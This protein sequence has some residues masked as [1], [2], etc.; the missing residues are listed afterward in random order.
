MNAINKFFGTILS[1]FDSFTGH[2]VL[3]LFL[4][5]LLVKVLLL[6]FGIKQ[7][8]NSVKQARFKPKEMAI[9]NKYKGRT[10]Q[11]TMQ[12]MQN[13]IMELYQKEGYNPMGGCLPLLIQMPIILIL[14][15]V[16]INPLKYICG[17]SSEMVTK[18]ASYLT[19]SGIANFVLNKN[20]VF[21]GRDIDLIQ[22]LTE[23]TVGGINEALGDIGQVVLTDLP[24]FG[25][26]GD[27][28][29]L[30]AKPYF[31]S[32]LLLI[33][34]LNFVFTMLSSIITRK[35]TFQPMQ[36][37][38]ANQASMK[39]MNVFMAGVTAAIAFGVPAAIGIYWLFN[40]LLGIAQQFI[41][42]KAIPLPKFTEEDYKK[43]EREYLGKVTKREQIER[44]KAALSRSMG[45]EECAD[46]GEYISVYDLK[47]SDPPAEEKSETGSSVIGKAPL[48]KKNKKSKK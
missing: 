5:A 34:L 7:Q 22:Y 40:N 24:N 36:D 20:G 9:R 21:A 28:I 43:A 42:Y 2:Y 33:P 6:P 19:D 11:P 10:D 35:L 30:A 38:A 3:A 16:I 15:Q 37:Q 8:K 26:F 27:G 17:Y 45:D 23:N 14:Y 44:T 47:P 1:A 46:L 31:W 25:L 39:I 12:K 4:F 29:A 13:E 41:L 32:W 18:I 48:K